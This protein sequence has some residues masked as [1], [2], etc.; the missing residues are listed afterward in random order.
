MSVPRY[1]HI[2]LS[3]GGILCSVN[4][5]NQDGLESAPAVSPILAAEQVVW[6]LMDVGLSTAEGCELGGEARKGGI[7]LSR[8]R[9]AWWSCPGHWECAH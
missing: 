7:A 3:I 4:S 5:T 6:L 1:N 2:F 8:S 9:M